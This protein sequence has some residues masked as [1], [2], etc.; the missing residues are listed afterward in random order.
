MA[1]LFR[2]SS[3]HP[4]SRFN[5]VAPILKM[6]LE[7]ELV[8]KREAESRRSE[9][10]RSNDQY[11][12]KWNV[13]NE[14]FDDWTSSRSAQLSHRQHA[15]K[16]S[17]AEVESRRE[18]LRELYKEDNLR[19]EA[20]L[21]QLEAAKEEEKWNLIK[22]K[23][24]HFRQTKQLQ[25]RDHIEKN[26]HEKWKSTSASFRAFESELRTQQIQEAL[27]RQRMEK[28]EQNMLE[29]EEKEKERKKMEQLQEEH[30]RRLED[31]RRIE[32][33]KKREWK[34]GLD[35]QIHILR[36][37]LIFGN[38]QTFPLYKDSFSFFF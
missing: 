11:F 5:S 21:K 31:E 32:V 38:K 24:E 35:Q 13:Q 18:K 36:Y 14:K 6:R 1:D 2:K 26:E 4:G 30:K 28:E 3:G 7:N 33:E 8:R 22:N 12:Q 19:Y 25:L 17:L 37:P 23:V 20:E 16:E 10:W 15:L 9:T 34:K 29:T 27:L